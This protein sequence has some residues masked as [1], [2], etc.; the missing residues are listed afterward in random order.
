M[1]TSHSS[2]R[3][4]DADYTQDITVA[5]QA[6]T[7]ITHVRLLF[8]VGPGLSG[9]VVVLNTSTPIHKAS[10]EWLRWVETY[11]FNS[12]ISPC[13][14]YVEGWEKAKCDGKGLG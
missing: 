13:A 14:I 2:T 1:R 7:S 3:T 9:G 6:S 12:N 8:V 11:H 10:N 5:I 4:R